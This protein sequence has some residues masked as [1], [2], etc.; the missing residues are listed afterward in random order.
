MDGRMGTYEEVR[1]CKSGEKK[2]GKPRWQGSVLAVVQ[3]KITAKDGRRYL[4]VNA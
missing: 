3:E 1:G 2:E 4:L